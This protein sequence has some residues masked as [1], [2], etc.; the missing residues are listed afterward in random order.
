[1]LSTMTVV[2]IPKDFDGEAGVVSEVNLCSSLVVEGGGGEGNSP[3]IM[4]YGRQ[5]LFYGTYYHH[6]GEKYFF[7]VIW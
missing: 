1:M 3:G 7:C 2:I 4:S 6:M 5:N